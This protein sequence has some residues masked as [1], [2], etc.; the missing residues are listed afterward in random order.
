[1]FIRVTVWMVVYSCAGV[2]HPGLSL[3][4]HAEAT[5]LS[6]DCL[7]RIYRNSVVE[8]TSLGTESALAS[9]I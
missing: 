4:G 6:L 7:K 9:L 1:M 5:T 3:I 2:V 8:G